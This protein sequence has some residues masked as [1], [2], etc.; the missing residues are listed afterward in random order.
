MAR[1]KKWLRLCGMIAGGLLI[2]CEPDPR[3]IPVCEIQAVEHQPEVFM[4]KG[5]PDAGY[6]VQVRLKN[7]GQAGEF[8]VRA[9]L[10]TSEGDMERTR[11]IS[12]Q[13]NE[14]EVIRFD[15]PE[16]TINASNIQTIAECW[17]R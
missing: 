13:A 11:T 12:L 10:G 5:E 9:R 1:A 6:K 3:F 7:I 14:L 2:G 17:W 8:R 15:F 4:I 16:P